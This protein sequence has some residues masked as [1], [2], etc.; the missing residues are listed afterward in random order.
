MTH[1]KM[2]Y[3]VTRRC[4]EERTE[5]EK[6]KKRKN[7]R[8]SKEKVGCSNNTYKIQIRLEDEEKCALHTFTMF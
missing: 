7:Y 2:V 4:K 6:N 8:K 5:M 3:L 1:D